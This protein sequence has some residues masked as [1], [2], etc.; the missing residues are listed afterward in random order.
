MWGHS[1]VECIDAYSKW[2]EIYAMSAT[3]AQATIQQL[4]KIFTVHG[5]P[6]LL[7]TDNGLQ[8]VASGFESFCQ[9]RG[10]HHTLTAPYHPRSNGEAER[11]VETFKL[12]INKADQKNATQLDDA[13]STSLLSTEQFL[14]PLQIVYL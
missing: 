10:I 8:F 6:E 4:H 1:E 7:I 9:S 12:A 11:L 5:L 13:I 14:I 2:P 3:T